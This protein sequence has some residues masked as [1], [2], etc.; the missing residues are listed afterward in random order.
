MAKLNIRQ[1]LLDRIKKIV[2]DY[3][4]AA[5]NQVRQQ[6]DRYEADGNAEIN[7]SVETAEDVVTAAVVATG[8]KA[9]LLEYGKGSKM[10]KSTTENPFL[11]E[12]ISGVVKE[13]SGDPLFNPKRIYHGLA[14]IGR[15]EGIYSDLDDIYYYS[16]GHV[17][18]R[19]IEQWIPPLPPR[20][21]IKTVL[22][23]QDGNG[24]I[25][26]EVNKEILKAVNEVAAEV[27][28]R[29][30]TEIVIAKGR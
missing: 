19:K 24:G 4:R 3:A 5:C 2:V 21:V 10:V 23:G 18:N 1:R 29:F 22:F 11:E 28:A 30:P 7:S 14:L 13:T 16:Y 12:Y 9:W 25:I 15:P 26:S 27:L 20:R 17:D 6:W 8:M